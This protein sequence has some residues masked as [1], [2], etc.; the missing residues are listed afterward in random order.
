MLYKTSY[1]VTLSSLIISNAVA[2]AIPLVDSSSTLGVQLRG[3]MEEIEQIWKPA[4]ANGS[5][6]RAIFRNEVL[7]RSNNSVTWDRGIPKT[8]ELDKPLDASIVMPNDIQPVKNILIKMPPQLKLI[9]LAG[10]RYSTEA[11]AI[12]EWFA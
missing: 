2:A 11:M 4:D 5:S 3:Y 1:K 6:E 8:M 10:D 9:V 12:S 7:R